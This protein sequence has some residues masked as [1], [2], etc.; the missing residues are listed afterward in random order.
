MRGSRSGACLCSECGAPLAA[1]LD[2]FAALGVPRRLT[3]DPKQIENLYHE[4]GRRV[5][6][7]RFASRASAVRDASLNATALLTRAF[8]T[9]RD[10]VSRGLYWLELQGEKLATDN[11]R[12]P[13]ELAELIFEVQE[14]LEEL[15]DAEG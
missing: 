3:I 11:Q 10:P 5:H 9:L 8:R 1:E 13:P 2:Y 15:R 6:P 7:D 4:L 12:V 14:T